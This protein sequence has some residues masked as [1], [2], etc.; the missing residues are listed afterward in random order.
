MGLSAIQSVYASITY[1]RAIYINYF[2][3]VA[4]FSGDNSVS[5][6]SYPMFEYLSIMKTLPFQR[7]EN[8]SRVT[9]ACADGDVSVYSHCAYCSHCKGSAHGKP[10]R[11]HASESGAI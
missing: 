11:S 5:I 1:M 3:W 7:D 2:D 9:V 10:N 4:V 8:K 6:F